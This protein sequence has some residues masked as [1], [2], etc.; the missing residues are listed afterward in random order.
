MLRRGGTVARTPWGAT[1]INLDVSFVQWSPREKPPGLG[2][3]TLAAAEIAGEI[4]ALSG[5]Y[6]VVG[7]ATAA[8]IVA[9]V[10]GVATD[11]GIAVTPTSNTEAVLEATVVT[12]DSVVVRVREPVYIRYED[13]PL[14]AKTTGL[15]PVASWTPSRALVPS[16]VRYG[17]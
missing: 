1:V 12:Q 16:S 9:G 2:G 8:G 15:S 4:V 17:Q 14:Y 10:A 3:T 6:S 13:I 5:P 7:A 11:M